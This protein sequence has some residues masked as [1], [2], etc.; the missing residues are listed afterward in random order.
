MANVIEGYVLGIVIFFYVLLRTF[1]P[2]KIARKGM[3]IIVMFSIVCLSGVVVY[4]IFPM[5]PE[6]K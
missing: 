2:K 3:I 4:F 5:L 1:T 6:P